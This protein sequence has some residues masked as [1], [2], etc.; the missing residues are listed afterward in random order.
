VIKPVEVAVLGASGFVGRNLVA[1]LKTSEKYQVIALARPEFDLCKPDTYSLIPESVD[2]IVHAAGAVGCNG[3]EKHYWEM[4]VI[5]AYTLANY[6][7]SRMKVPQIVY[8]STGAVYSS[9]DHPLRVTDN[10]K[11]SSLYGMS[12]YC[13]EEIFRCYSSSPLAVLRL[14]F[15]YG[16]GQSDDRFMPNLCRKIAG[17]EP[18]M[19]NIGDRPLVNPIFIDDLVSILRNIIDS[20]TTGIMNIGGPEVVS[21]RWLAEKIAELLGLQA[22]FVASNNNVHDMYCDTA[23]LTHSVKLD[24]GL[25][26]MIQEMLAQ[27]IRGSLL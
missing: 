9:T 1:S 12:K 22:R 2:V 10:I 7:K 8:L 11:P 5:S 23:E 27:S 4:N 21:I 15:P 20:H 19:L 26:L 16:P 17:G 13:A 14:F 25:K 24:T 18:V 3:D 6:L